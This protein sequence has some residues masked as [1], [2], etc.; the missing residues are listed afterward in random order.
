MHHQPTCVGFR[1]V[2][3]KSADLSKTALKPTQ[4]HQALR[5][6][7]SSEH[8]S[9]YSGLHHCCNNRRTALAQDQPRGGNHHES[10]VALRAEQQPCLLCYRPYQAGQGPLRCQVHTHSKPYTTGEQGQTPIYSCPMLPRLPQPR[11]CL[12]HSTTLPC[13]AGVR[14]LLLLKP[15][16]TAA[17]AASA[18]CASLQTSQQQLH[19]R[20]S[21]CYCSCSSTEWP[22]VV[23]QMATIDLTDSNTTVRMQVFQQHQVH[24]HTIKCTS[25]PLRTVTMPP[26]LWSDTQHSLLTCP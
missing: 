9:L 8:L 12:P 7:S 4:H 10:S 3:D 5:A 1:A 20:K 17:A 26:T 24:T 11:S 18:C 16:P 21:C 22:D 19:Y 13:V 23:R 15:L 14:R 2:L 25:P 6:D